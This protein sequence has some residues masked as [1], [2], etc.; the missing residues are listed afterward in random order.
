MP[1]PSRRPGLSLPVAGI[2]VVLGALA[3]CSLSPQAPSGLLQSSAA[4]SP[5]GVRG[6]GL[7]GPA[8]VGEDPVVF[9]VCKRSPRS[10]VCRG[11]VLS[12]EDC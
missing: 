8:A 6:C 1:S 10:A 7:A 12:L 3:S 2:Y 4:E 11:G 5:H 9:H